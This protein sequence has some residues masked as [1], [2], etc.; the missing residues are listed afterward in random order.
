MVMARLRSR[1]RD[2]F[3]IVHD[4]RTRRQGIIA[5]PPKWFDKVVGNWISRVAE[6][7]CKCNWPR[8]EL[9]HDRIKKKKNRF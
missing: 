2:P 1:R 6:I 8:P 4:L 9:C 5:V 3:I 7:I